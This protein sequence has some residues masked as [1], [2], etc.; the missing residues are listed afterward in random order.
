MTSVRSAN[1]TVN[2]RKPP[3]NKDGIISTALLPAHTK[4]YYFSKKKITAKYKTL[5]EVPKRV[6]PK[7][8]NP[9]KFIVKKNE[10]T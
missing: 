4:W 10:F 7:A 3:A 6:I 5:I 1:V 9:I 8:E 2:E